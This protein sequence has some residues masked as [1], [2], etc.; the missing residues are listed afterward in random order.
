MAANQVGIVAAVTDAIR[1]FGG[2]VVE[3]SQTV[4]RG[5]FTIILSV[6][7]PDDIAADRVLTEV[8]RTGDPFGL[9][10]SL[11]DPG[12]EPTPVAPPAGSERYVL[13]VTGR[14]RPGVIHEITRLLAER[15]IDITDLYAVSRDDQFMMV[16]EVYVPHDVAA[17]E[18]RQELQAIGDSIGLSAQFQHENIFRATNSPEPVEIDRTTRTAHV[19]H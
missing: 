10:V 16:L 8:R 4:M 17:P 14:D 7:V 11:K 1:A 13:T 19:P 6:E 9:E 12:V 18:L 15:S 2:N 3:L 5:F